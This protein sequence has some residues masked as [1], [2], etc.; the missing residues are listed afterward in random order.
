MF[1]VEA[2]SSSQSQLCTEP[3]L[4]DGQAVG[5]LTRTVLLHPHSLG[6]LCEL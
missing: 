5:S 3:R 4:A 6:E 1:A 2:S